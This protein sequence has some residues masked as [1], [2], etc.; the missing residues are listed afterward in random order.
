LGLARRLQ[1]SNSLGIYSV[2]AWAKFTGAAGYA[3]M[4]HRYYLNMLV[5][6]NSAGYRQLQMFVYLVDVPDGLARPY[7]FSRVQTENL[8][9]RPSWY[10]HT[11]L[12]TDDDGLPAAQGAGPAGHQGQ[13]R[14]AALPPGGDEQPGWCTVAS[15]GPGTD[16]DRAGL[17]QRQH[18]A[19]MLSMCR[20]SIRLMLNDQRS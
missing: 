8:P 14:A 16:P 5:P 18:R 17:L 19:P 20:P 15:T 13:A 2:K 11:C 4:L 12:G 7:I 1:G 3:Q 6:A 10:P 9:A